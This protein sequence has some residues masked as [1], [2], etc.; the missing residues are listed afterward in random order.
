MGIIISLTAVYHRILD[1]KLPLQIVYVVEFW[2][3]LMFLIS[4]LDLL[5]PRF[6]STSTKSVILFDHKTHMYY[7]T[8]ECTMF[9][10]FIFWFKILHVGK[11][12][13]KNFNMD[14]LSPGIWMYHFYFLFFFMVSSL[15]W[16]S[17]DVILIWFL[18]M[19]ALILHLRVLV[20]SFNDFKNV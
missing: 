13:G 12:W 10:S 19:W 7:D 5:C 8:M 20:A 18:T 16:V 17:N 2:L 3:L 1:M 6:M 11:V 14:Y 9:P 15:S 4:L